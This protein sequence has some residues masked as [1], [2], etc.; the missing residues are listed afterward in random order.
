MVRR[1]TPQAVLAERFFTVRVRVLLPFGARLDRIHEW[2]D[3]HVGK[4]NYWIGS[5]CARGRDTPTFFFSDTFAAHRFALRFA[6][7]VIRLE[8]G[9]EQERPR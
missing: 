4:R 1:S 9:R 8:P 6:D 3:A 5:D 2:L 7:G